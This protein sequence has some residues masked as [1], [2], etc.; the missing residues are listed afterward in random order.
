MRKWL[1]SG[2]AAGPI[3]LAALAASAALSSGDRNFV[4]TAASGGQRSRRR[5]LRSS[6]PP[7][8]R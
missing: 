6:I 5:S 8:L 3:A 4:Q 7:R 1:R 2:L